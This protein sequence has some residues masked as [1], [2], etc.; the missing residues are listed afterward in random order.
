[1]GR[2]VSGWM[3]VLWGLCLCWDGFVTKLSRFVCVVVLCVWGEWWL[4]YC[5]MWLVLFS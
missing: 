3:G 5:C 4:V 2:G 1:M